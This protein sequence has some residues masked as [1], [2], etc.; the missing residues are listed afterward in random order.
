MNIHDAT[1]VAYRNGY[2]KGKADGR[3]ARGKAVAIEI[4]VALYN[5][6]IAAR[7][8]NYNAIKEREIK[9]NVN[10]YEDSFCEYCN[11]KIRALDGILNF[12]DELITKYTGSEECSL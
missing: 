3:L 12:L 5:E 1:E 11:G 2:E 10:R 7:E 9:H 8:S 4:Y 6:I